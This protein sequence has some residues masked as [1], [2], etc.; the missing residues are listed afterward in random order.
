MSLVN[1]NQPGLQPSPGA[2]TLAMEVQQALEARA[3]AL[4]S[5]EKWRKRYES[6]AQQ[7]R[8]ESQ[9]AEETIQRLRTEL[10]QMCQLGTQSPLPSRV[11]P[12][13]AA[14]DLSSS[15]L[16]RLAAEVQQLRQEKNQLADL[17]AQEQSR[18][19]QTKE[20]LMTALSDAL[21]RRSP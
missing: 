1:A 19:Q 4:E 16:E 9:Q 11:Q 10:A 5:A 2:S 14:S 18:H 15:T 7:R 13:R 17:L 21:Q 20:N 3:Q 12:T 8:T 6:E